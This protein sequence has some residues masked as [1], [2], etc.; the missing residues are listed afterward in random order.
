MCYFLKK[1]FFIIYQ[2][3]LDFKHGPCPICSHV[4]DIMTFNAAR[5]QGL[6]EMFW[7]HHKGAVMLHILM[8]SDGCILIQGD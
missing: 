5:H 6:I 7:L 1:I 3:T 8:Q 4:A 2:C